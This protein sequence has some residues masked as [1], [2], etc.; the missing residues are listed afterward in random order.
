MPPRIIF[1]HVRNLL[2]LM[3]SVMLEYHDSKRRN[4]YRN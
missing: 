4:G 3:R 1:R 2:S